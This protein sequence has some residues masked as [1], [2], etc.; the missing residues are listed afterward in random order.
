LLKE[1]IP[2]IGED[3]FPLW[4]VCEDLFFWGGVIEC[5]GPPPR[6][7]PK[8]MYILIPGNCNYVVIHGRRDFA[9]VI[10]DL[11]R[12]DYPRLAEWG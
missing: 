2:V 3:S 4:S 9:N 12:E 6:P 5:R 11:E 8:I 1:I 10:K 7:P